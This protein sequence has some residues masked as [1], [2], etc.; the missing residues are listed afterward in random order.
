[1]SWAEKELRKARIRKQVDAVLNSPEYKRQQREHDLKVF[2]V[3]C[4]VSVDYLVRNEG[5]KAKRVQRFLDFVKEQMHYI[6]DDEEY[7]FNLLNEAL[8]EDCGVN[9]ME[10]MDF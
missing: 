2:L 1:M 10:Y 9:V 3:Y 8:E 5:Y 4:I 7:D 6:S